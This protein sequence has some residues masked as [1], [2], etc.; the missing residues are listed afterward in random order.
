MLSLRQPLHSGA[1][2]LGLD[3]HLMLLSP[4]VRAGTAAIAT[5]LFGWW[6]PNSVYGLVGERYLAVSSF[7]F[8]HCGY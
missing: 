3:G 6:L 1:G 8:G 7:A 2:L 4:S 5:A